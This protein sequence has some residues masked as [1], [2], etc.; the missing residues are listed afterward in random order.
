MGIALGRRPPCDVWDWR[1]WRTTMLIPSTM[2]LPAL[3]S[4][5]EMVPSL[6]LSL[7]ASTTTL[8]PFFSLAAMSQHLRGERDDLHEVLGAQFAHPRAENPCAERFTCVI[9][10]D[11]GIA[12]ETDGGAVF[13]ANF[14][15]GAHDDGLAD[16]ALLQAA[17][18]DGFLDRDDDNVAHGRVFTLGTTQDLDALNPAGAGVVSNIQIGLHL[19]HLVSPDLWGRTCVSLAP[20]FRS[21]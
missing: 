14:F 13:T 18:R 19:D 1:V 6:P 17:A 4:T 12:V 8:S 11:G 20:W 7:P 3:G 16:V 21:N 10:D 2:A 15:G 5:E 9:Q